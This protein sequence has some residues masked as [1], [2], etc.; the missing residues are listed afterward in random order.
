[1]GT[2][3]TVSLCRY[4]TEMW[5]PISFYLESGLVV[6][7]ITPHTLALHKSLAILGLKTSP[8]Q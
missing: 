8:S 2:I 4:L 3:V 7:I 5:Y 1:M 6:K